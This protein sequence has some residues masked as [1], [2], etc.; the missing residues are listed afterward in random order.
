LVC[1]VTSHELI[2]PVTQKKFT[3]RGQAQAK[4]IDDETEKASLS[5]LADGREERKVAYESSRW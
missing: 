4:K 3:S 1:E 5:V 2:L